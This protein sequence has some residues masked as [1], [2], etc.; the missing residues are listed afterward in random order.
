M[1]GLTM[2]I[3]GLLLGACR[4]EIPVDINKMMMTQNDLR[5]QEREL[6]RAF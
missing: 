6:D 3:L 1:V 5:Q 4:M 2:L